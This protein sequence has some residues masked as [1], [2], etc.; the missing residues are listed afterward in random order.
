MTSQRPGCLRRRKGGGMSCVMSS[1]RPVHVTVANL[2]AHPR[3]ACRR[4]TSGCG[5]YDALDDTTV[6]GRGRA[7]A[8]RPVMSCHG[9]RCAARTAGQCQ[10]ATH[11]CVA[12]WNGSMAG[13]FPIH[14]ALPLGSIK[15]QACHPRLC[16]LSYLGWLRRCHCIRI[17]IGIRWEGQGRE[18]SG[19]RRVGAPCVCVWEWLPCGFAAQH[20]TA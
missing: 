2:P 9:G 16:V 7:A 14:P 1:R 11:G 20:S 15:G 10:C 6:G 4:W 13:F 12:E 18:G 3:A 17:R 19:R 5:R 8:R